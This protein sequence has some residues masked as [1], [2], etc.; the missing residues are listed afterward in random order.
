MP[1]LHGSE[2][3]PPFADD[4]V[5]ERNSAAIPAG[6]IHTPNMQNFDSTDLYLPTDATF[7]AWRLAIV[8]QAQNLIHGIADNLPQKKAP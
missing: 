2:K 1:H 8:E 6:H 7:D 5:G 4:A 3:C